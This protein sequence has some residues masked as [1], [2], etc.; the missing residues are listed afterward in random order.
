MNL[1]PGSRWRQYIPGVTG[2]SMQLAWKLLTSKKPEARAALFMAVGGVA[3]MPLDALLARR[4]AARYAAAP[5]PKQSLIL[6]CGPA[7][8]G[9]TL[10]AQ[11]LINSLNVAHINNL[12][13]LFPRSPLTANK[14][15]ARCLPFREGNYAAYYG[16][17][18]FLSGVNDGLHLWDRWLGSDR[19]GI[20]T[21]LSSGATV[22]LPQFFGALQACDNRPLVNKA[23]RLFTCAHLVA[24]L[25]PDAIFICLRRDPV[26]LAQSLLIARTEI[27]GDRQIPYGIHHDNRIV[28]DPVEDV[29]RQ[30]EFYD[31]QIQ[32]QQN[33]LGS[34]KFMVIDYEAFCAKPD[35][36]VALLRESRGM[37]IQPRCSDT[38]NRTAAFDV[39]QSRRVSNEEYRVLQQRLS[40]LQ[41]R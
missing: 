20:P 18:R 15:F 37:S 25:L 35:G 11:Y 3:L 14:L 31:A 29:C 30:V 13:S 17:S 22:S 27:T 41:E 38:T 6:V 4:E 33:L 36:L 24:P 23:N 10:V 32:K 2:N 16:R 7:R 5:D 28:Q 40:T 9:T 34:D 8:S 1:K 21:S 26:Q 12:S 19:N 39:S